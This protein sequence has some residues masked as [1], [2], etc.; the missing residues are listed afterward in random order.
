MWIVL[1]VILVVII[2]FIGWLIGMYN[3]LVRLAQR[4]EECVQPDRCAAETTL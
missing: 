1:I 4:G 3:G 2:I